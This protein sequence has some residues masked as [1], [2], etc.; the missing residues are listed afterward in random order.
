MIADLIETVPDDLLDQSGKVFYSG[1]DAFQPGRPVYVLGYNP[2]GAPADRPGETLRQ[3][4][5]DVTR[6]RPANW[7]AY[8]DECW[9]GKPAGRAKFQPVMCDFL[10]SLGLDPGEVPA[11]NLIFVRSSRAADLNHAHTHVDRCWPFH[12]RV[13]DTVNPQAIIALGSQTGGIIRSRLKVETEIARFVEPNNRGWTSLA[14]RAPDGRL[15]FTL[16]HPS[17]ARWTTPATDP[18]NM[19]TSVLIETGAIR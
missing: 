4:I 5:D 6:R 7:S 17:V 14:H 16:T 12:A 8:R 1:R 13:L 10:E 2:G 15:I 9:G 11:S 18:R 19:V 3:N